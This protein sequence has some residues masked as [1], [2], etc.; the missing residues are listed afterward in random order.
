[1]LKRSLGAVGV[2]L[3]LTGLPLVAYA[4]EYQANFSTAGW[5]F[6]AVYRYP[7]SECSDQTIDATTTGSFKTDVGGC[8]SKAA[9]YSTRLMRDITALPDQVMA[10]YDE[11]DFCSPAKVANGYTWKKSKFHFDLAN[12]YYPQS[13]G[14]GYDK[15]SSS[16]S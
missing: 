14:T 7:G 11:I 5:Q 6:G 1:M 16:H 2:G 9:G 15:V 3:L 10:N 8:P 4:N 12:S 13:S